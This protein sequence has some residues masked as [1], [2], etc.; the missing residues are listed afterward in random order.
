MHTYTHI[1][2]QTYLLAFNRNNSYLLDVTLEKFD[3]IT[4]NNKSSYLETITTWFYL[5]LIKD[6]KNRHIPR[7]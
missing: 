5:I 6:T 7:A 4:L 3:V 2:T 1:H